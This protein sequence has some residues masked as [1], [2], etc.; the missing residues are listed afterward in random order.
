MNDREVFQKMKALR[1]FAAGCFAA[2]ALWAASP[3]TGEW[4]GD[5]SMRN[6]NVMHVTM[7]L[8]AQDGGG[9]TGTIAGRNG[10]V[11]IADG[12]VKDNHV[13]FNVVREF[14]DRQFKQHYDGTLDGDTI[15]FT[16]TR[17]GGMGRMGGGRGR[18]FDVQRVTK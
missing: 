6:G 13:S 14:D 4:K 18:T 17:E 3:A 2:A 7:D 9:L 15:H 8:K 11:E 1:V 16:V 12:K 10:P 5:I